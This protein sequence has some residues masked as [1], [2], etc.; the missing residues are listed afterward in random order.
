MKTLSSIDTRAMKTIN[1][2]YIDC[3]YL[4]EKIGIRVP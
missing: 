4:L 1:Y 3:P 2:I